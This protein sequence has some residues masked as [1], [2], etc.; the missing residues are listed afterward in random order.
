MQQDYGGIASLSSGTVTYSRSLSYNAK[1]QILVDDSTTMRLREGSTTLYD[2]W[3]TITRNDYDA[4]GNLNTQSG[5]VGYVLGSIIWQHGQTYKNGS[6]D[7]IDD[8][9][10]RFDYAYWD[11]AVQSGIAYDKHYGWS[12]NN[13]PTFNLNNFNTNF[14]TSY[15]LNGFGQTSAAFVN[16]GVARVT[17]T[18]H[19]IIFRIATKFICQ[20]FIWD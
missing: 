12:N 14:T 6:T 13:G 2:T 1:N 4:D 15:T 17:V 5:G 19:L 7:A 3:R 10:T 9:M 16:D 18:V 20:C 8:T 11:S